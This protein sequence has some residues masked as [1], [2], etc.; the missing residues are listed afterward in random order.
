MEN[1]VKSKKGKTCTVLTYEVSVRVT[2]WVTCFRSAEIRQLSPTVNR[3]QVCDTNKSESLTELVTAEVS[4]L[5]CDY[6]SVWT[7]LFIDYICN[8]NTNSNS[9]STSK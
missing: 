3:L 4:E 5:K 6:Q 7:E 9:S 1:L 8:T 2:E